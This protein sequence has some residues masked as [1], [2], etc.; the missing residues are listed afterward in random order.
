M[1]TCTI[2]YF[3]VAKVVAPKKIALKKANAELAEAMASLEKKR[4]SLKEVQDKLEKLTEK[5]EFNKQKKVDLENQ[6]DLCTKKLARAE[7]LIGGLGGE[8][9]RWGQ[10]AKDLAIKYTNSTGDVLVS[11]GIVAYLGCFTSAF[12]SVSKESYR[13]EYLAVEPA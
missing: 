1:N 12:R 6:V 3:R 4:A 8:K 7:Q 2:I 5:L 13:K 11:S 10:A 9:E